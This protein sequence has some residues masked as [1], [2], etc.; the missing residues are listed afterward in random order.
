MKKVR[1]LFK[2]RMGSLQDGDVGIEVE[3]EGAKLP[4][5]LTRWRM[6]HDGSLQPNPMA[7]EYVMPRPLNLEGAKES[8]RE[9][10][11]GLKVKGCVPRPSVRCGVHV[12]VNVQD[13][14]LI[15]LYNYFTA[16]LALENLLTKTCGEAREGNLFCLRAADAYYMVHNLIE[17]SR[18]KQF[19]E[20]FHN[21]DLRYS[22]MNVTALPKYGSLEFR[23]M[24]TT[25]EP[26]DIL[27][28]A[29]ALLNL[30]DFAKGFDNPTVLI[31]E[32]S[33]A[34]FENFIRQAVPNMADQLL[35]FPNCEDM[36]Y[37]GVRMA[38]DVAYSSDWRAVKEAK[39]L[40]PFLAAKGL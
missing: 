11:L 9:L 17:A 28:W 8:L 36:L 39:T 31:S 24:R 38:Q 7:V 34:G 26:L 20:L 6:E 23:A 14:T 16:Y 5:E 4:A 1:E 40:N 27:P 29:T 18:S 35:A 37:E 12:H 33:A 13:L 19:Y 21:D 3:M 25:T 22:A 32:L 15:E 10:S 30:R 2:L